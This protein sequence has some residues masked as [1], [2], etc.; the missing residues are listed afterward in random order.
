METREFPERTKWTYVPPYHGVVSDTKLDLETPEGAVVNL[1]PAGVS[2]RG[3]AFLVDLG[4]KVTVVILLSS[5][6][7]LIWAGTLGTMIMGLSSFFLNWFY[8]VAFEVFND[9]VTPGKRMFN[10]RVV[11]D[12]G[13]PI[14]LPASLLRNLI[15]FADIFPLPITGVA[16][17]ALSRNF[18]RIADHVAETLVIYEDTIRPT[19]DSIGV[20]AT[21]PPCEF[22]PSEQVLLLDFQDR[23]ARLSVA[24]SREL[25]EI[26]YPLHQKRGQAAVDSILGYA[27]GIRGT[28]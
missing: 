26:L 24:R 14:R 11:N 10:I 25:A 17:M 16:A 20:E 15:G 13:T 19:R 4:I 2:A 1:K 22:T 23:V 7:T 27:A 8:G 6:L 28:V 5:F 21:P 12:D 3:S 18:K 9:G